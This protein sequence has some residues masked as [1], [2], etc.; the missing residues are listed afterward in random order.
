VGAAVG[1]DRVVSPDGVIVMRVF[2]RI[3]VAL[4]GWL[5][6]DALDAEVAEEL[7]FHLERQIQ[8]NIN[9]GMTPAE[10][11]RA[12]HLVVGSVEAVREE[13]RDARPGAWTH[14][15]VRDLAFGTRLLRRTPAFALTAACI[16]ALGIGTTTTIF[17]V[18]YGVMLRPPP[19]PHPDRLVTLWTRQPPPAGRETINPADHREMR[20]NNGVFEDIALFWP[21]QNFNLIGAGEPER[22]FAARISSN[23]FSVLDVTPALGRT[24]TDDEDES[25]RDRVVVLSD[26][27]WKR[28]FGGNPALVGRTIN[29]TG[30]PYEVVGVMPPDFQYPGREHQLWV[31]LTINPAQLTRQVGGFDHMAVARMKPGVSLRQAQSALDTIAS[32]LEADHPA[33]HRGVRLEVLP[34]FEQSIQP[35]RRTLYVLLAAVLC[36]LLTACLNLANLLG[37]RAASRAREFT[38]RLAL[39]ASRGRLTLQALAEVA[40]VLC[41]GGI[42]GIAAAQIAIAA[43]VPLAPPGLPRADRIEIN[44]PV[45]AFSIGALGLTGIV[46]GL[47]PALHAWRARMLTPAHESRSATSS[48]ERVRTRNALAVA[49]LALALPLLVGAT[50]LGRSFSA[51]MHVDP[52]FRTDHIVSMHL[53]ISRSTHKNDEQ[54]ALFCGRVVEQVAALPGVESAGMVNRL[55]LSGNSQVM[56]FAFEGVGEKPLMFQSRTVTPDYFRTIGIPLLQG[57]LFTSEDRA[58]SPLVGI[59][60]ERLARALWPGQSAVGRRFGVKLPGQQPASAEIVGVVGHVR[61]DGLDKDTDR[62]VYFSHP[63]FTD[64]RMVLVVRSREDVRALI[65]AVVQAIRTVDPDQPVYDVRTMD[66][67]VERS[68]AQRWLNTAIVAVFAIAS[69]LLACV[70]LYGVIAYGVTQ[71]LREFGVRLALGATRADVLRLV[72]GRGSALAACGTALGLIGAVVLTQAMEGLL[73]G[74][75]PLDPVGFFAAALLLFTVALLAGYFPARRAARTNPAS[76]LR[77]E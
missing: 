69:L 35:V 54:V 28:R 29:L 63:Q 8:A 75:K 26:R 27:L 67:V 5:W 34:L 40:P 61:H 25:G 46:A 41:I 16:V 38:V 31:P 64:G 77:V 17:S 33:T 4:R 6:P 73:Y 30:V 1:C 60:D 56:P 49:Q 9:A 14:Q 57:R 53:A 48:R 50:A 21:T 51:L 7:R 23:L 59:I 32:R 52:G 39:G 58:D 37:S 42:A 68:T 3:A 2:D 72:L 74:V 20:H 19:F 44:A 11:R 65:P 55:P 10:A 24:F 43:F 66:D 13:S 62:Q 47:L 45:L 18:V 76:V 36:L 71:R 15:L 22:V 70:G 12:A